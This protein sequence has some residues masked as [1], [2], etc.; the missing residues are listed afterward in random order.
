M[1][2]VHSDAVH[3][4]YESSGFPSTHA[5]PNGAFVPSFS[6]FSLSHLHVSNSRDGIFTSLDV[7]A[8][9]H[10]ARLKTRSGMITPL[11]LS[12]N[13][14]ESV[15]ETIDCW[16]TAAPLL[17]ERCCA[18]HMDACRAQLRSPYYHG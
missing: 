8:T 3:M 11:A 6:S 10:L 4:Q 7:V 17:P 14:L 16:H 13:Y 5:A 18:S 1:Y 12:I 9:G 2:Q 15:P